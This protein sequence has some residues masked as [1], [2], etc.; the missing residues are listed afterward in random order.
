M[1]QDVNYPMW[2]SFIRF[3]WFSRVNTLLLLMFLFLNKTFQNIITFFIIRLSN[4]TC[5]QQISHA[6]KSAILRIF[7][8]TPQVMSLLIGSCFCVSLTTSSFRAYF[9]EMYMRRSYK[10]ARR[11]ERGGSPVAYL[12]YVKFL[13]AKQ[14][15]QNSCLAVRC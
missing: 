6:S 14:Q 11:K 9:N 5:S 13:Y 1:E 4:S 12:F 8:H 2:F 7:S 15:Q 3:A 10:T